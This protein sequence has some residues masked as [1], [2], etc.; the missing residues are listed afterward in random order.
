MLELQGDVMVLNAGIVAQL[1]GAHI[2]VAQRVALVEHLPELDQEL[3]L[4]VGPVLRLRGEP[5]LLHRVA[6]VVHLHL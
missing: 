4:L 1:A 3:T 5:Q 2:R 6:H